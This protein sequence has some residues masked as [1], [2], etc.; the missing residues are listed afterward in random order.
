L[1]VPSHNSGSKSSEETVRAKEQKKLK[2]TEE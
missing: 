1:G 2:G